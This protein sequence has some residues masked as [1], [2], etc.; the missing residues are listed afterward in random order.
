MEEQCRERERETNFVEEI[1]I[2]FHLFQFGRL[3]T[4]DLRILIDGQNPGAETSSGLGRALNVERIER[5]ELDDLRQH[6]EDVVRDLILVEKDQIVEEII[7]HHQHF[8]FGPSS[9]RE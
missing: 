7:F 8:R 5:V 4:S 3:G 1:L 6:L 2:G 9:R